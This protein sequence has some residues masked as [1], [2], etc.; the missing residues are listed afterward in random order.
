ML[1]GTPEF[2]AARWTLGLAELERGRHEEAIDHLRQ[3]VRLTAEN[4]ARLAELGYAYGRAGRAEDAAR[5]L[6][7]LEGLAHRRRVSSADLALVELGLG[8]RDAA[9]DLLDKAYSE[10]SCLFLNMRLDPRLDSLRGEPRFQRLL[11]R[12]RW[13]AGPGRG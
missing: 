9:L 6:A 10:R 2:A 3:T 13:P 4:P 5:V 12:L 7:Q 8:H 1:D 11:A